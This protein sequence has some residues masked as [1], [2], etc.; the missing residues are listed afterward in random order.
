MAQSPTSRT[1]AWLREQG[2]LPAVVE[3]RLPHCFISQDLFG[4]IDV[5]AIKPGMPVLGVQATSTSNVSARLKKSL[6]V[7]ELRTWLETGCTFEVHGWGLRGPAGKRKQWT[8][9][10]RVVDLADLDNKE[11]A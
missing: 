7:P 3:R 10:R 9:S 6:A 1:L 8:L 4:C 2:Y 11:N 5:L